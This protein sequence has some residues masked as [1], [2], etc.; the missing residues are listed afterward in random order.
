MGFAALNS[1][2]EK[3]SEFRSVVIHRNDATIFHTDLEALRF[4]MVTLA[5]GANVSFDEEHPL[6]GNDR[7]RWADRLAI[8][9]CG[10]NFSYDLH[11]HCPVP[12]FLLAVA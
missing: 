3:R 11:C 10:A 7:R 8:S 2:Y 5:F 4:V 1:S 9:A 12:F 6:L